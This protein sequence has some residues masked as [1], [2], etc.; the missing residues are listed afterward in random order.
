M[1]RQVEEPAPKFTT[2]L[3]AVIWVLTNLHRCDDYVRSFEQKVKRL[4]EQNALTFDTHIVQD[5]GGDEVLFV[6]I[7]QL[8]EEVLN[9]R[10][11]N[12]QIPSEGEDATIGYFVSQVHQ[13]TGL[14][15]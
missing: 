13:M 1:N 5:L 12:I 11:N 9:L 15:L 14:P 3:R 10:V 8:L 4:L 2:A 6:Y 7:E